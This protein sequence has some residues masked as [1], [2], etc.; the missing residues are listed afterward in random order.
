[1][2]TLNLILLC[3]LP[4]VVKIGYYLVPFHKLLP[5]HEHWRKVAETLK[6]SK[7]AKLR[8]E[9]IIY[10]HATAGKNASLTARHFGIPRKTIL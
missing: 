10:Y 6:L 2:L 4:H 1:M 8:L 5:R 3:L 7:P 9:W